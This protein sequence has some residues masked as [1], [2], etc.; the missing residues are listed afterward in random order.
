MIR[1]LMHPNIQVRAGSPYA[2][3]APREVTI[4]VDVPGSK[5]GVLEIGLSYSEAE[6]LAADILEQVR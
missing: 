5:F 2:V 1:R 6:S 3:N 4:L